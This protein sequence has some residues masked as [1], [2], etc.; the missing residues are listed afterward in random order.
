LQSRDGEIECAKDKR[1]DVVYLFKRLMPLRVTRL[2]TFIHNGLRMV[3]QVKEPN[4]QWV[5]N[6]ICGS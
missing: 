1:S 6:D 3:T 5:D 2:F 4:P